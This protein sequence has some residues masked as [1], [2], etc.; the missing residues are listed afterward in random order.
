[1]F[2]TFICYVV[3][4]VSFLVSQFMLNLS[5]SVTDLKLVNGSFL[6]YNNT[7]YKIGAVFRGI[8]DQAIEI[9]WIN[10]ESQP[11]NIAKLDE[12]SKTKKKSFTHMIGN[13][14]HKNHF[15]FY[16]TKRF[17]ICVLLHK[18][19]HRR[20]CKENHLIT[21][22]VH[23]RPQK[24]DGLYGK[25]KFFNTRNFIMRLH[26]CRFYSRFASTGNCYIFMLY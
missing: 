14:S 19:F 17:Q 4:S 9:S 20:N 24:R 7:I 23:L 8:V 18:K 16:P 10:L 22:Y 3:L 13:T 26:F 6:H 21:P 2:F 15:V 1:M 5:L 12:Y 25:I 11:K